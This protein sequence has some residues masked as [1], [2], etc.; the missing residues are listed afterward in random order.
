MSIT[1]R[2]FMAVAASVVSLSCFS[3]QIVGFSPSSRKQIEIY[4]SPTK[5]DQAQATVATKDIRLP[6]DVLRT[7][8]GFHEV[9]IEGKPGW[10]RSAHIQQSKKSVAS[11]PQGLKQL[12]LTN[13]T[14]GAGN[15]GCN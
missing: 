3:Q 12:A 9:L 10:V 7:E 1:I 2:T 11:C 15:T 6:L 5:A 4:A 13:S 14:P 8:S